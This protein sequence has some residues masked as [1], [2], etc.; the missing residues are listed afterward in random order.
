ML[1]RHGP[2]FVETYGSLSV[3]IS[4]GMEKMH[5]AAKTAYSRHTQHSGGLLRKSPVEQIFQHSYRCIQH[6]DRKNKSLATSTTKHDE[7]DEIIET[8]AK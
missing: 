1:V 3:W 4:Q 2:W 6:W 8:H 5:A 7:I